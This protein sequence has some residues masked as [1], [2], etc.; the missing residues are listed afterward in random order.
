MYAERE[1]REDENRAMPIDGNAASLPAGVLDMLSV[2]AAKDTQGWLRDA[3]I[4]AVGT[5]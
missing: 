1:W 3:A 2:L 5:T 4:N